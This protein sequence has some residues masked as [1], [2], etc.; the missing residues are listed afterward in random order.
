MQ[1]DSMMERF[2]R[3]L[4]LLRDR[5]VLYLIN[6]SLIFGINLILAYAMFQVQ[7]SENE[8]RNENIANLITTEF[9]VVISFFIHNSLTWRHSFG[10]IWSKLWR[11]HLVSAGSLTIRTAIFASLSYLGMHEMFA[12]VLSIA[13][14]LFFNFVGFDRF[15]FGQTS[16]PATDKTDQEK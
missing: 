6:G 14:I 9:M 4:P 1:P 5:R 15:A 12:T 13:F 16:D 11:F 8:W 3:L 2:S 10:S 7:W